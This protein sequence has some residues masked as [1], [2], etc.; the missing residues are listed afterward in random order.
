MQELRCP[1]CN[2]KLA[3]IPDDY[4]DTEEGKDINRNRGKVLIKCTKC[5]K[6]VD[7]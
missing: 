3:E 1:T 4:F 6:I 2:K 7:F 5:K